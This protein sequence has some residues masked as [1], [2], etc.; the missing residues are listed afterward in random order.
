MFLVTATTPDNGAV[1]FG[2]DKISLVMSAAVDPTTLNEGLSL[3]TPDMDL[4]GVTRQIA[5]GRDDTVELIPNSPLEP[6]EY[7]VIVTSRL[8]SMFGEALS[9]GNSG[10]VYTRFTLS[11]TL[12]SNGGGSPS[13]DDYRL[14]AI[15]SLP[16]SQT[17]G[18]KQGEAAV[19]F[20]EPIEVLKVIAAVGG[21]LEDA[22][23]I[24]P[25]AVATVD[26]STLLL[27][28]S[29]APNSRYLFDMAV[30]GLESGQVVSFKL[31]Y[32]SYLDPGY[33][34]VNQVRS[35][36]GSLIKA[37]PNLAVF[38]M[39]SDCSVLAEGLSQAANGMGQR[40]RD[41]ALKQYTRYTVEYRLLR[42]FVMS[43]LLA[44]K[45]QKQLGQFSVSHDTAISPK[46]V[47]LLNKL[48][49]EV[50]HWEDVL[51]GFA[52]LGP[53]TPQSAVKGAKVFLV[54]PATRQIIRDEF[55]LPL[56]DPYIPS[57][58]HLPNMWEPRFKRPMP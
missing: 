13:D 52:G 30:R 45:D 48:Q 53:A 36:L 15:T 9:T 23:T 4:I 41:L 16:A 21:N 43:N 56:R 40:T 14:G 18:L 17:Y 26:D 39:A 3:I 11:Q 25:T 2:L 42:E 1:V 44:Q 55:K 28:W 57:R 54:N 19:V 10:V 50:L 8:T 32:Y 27:N 38:L 20:N 46:A 7:H 37:I 5:P 35:D 12:P 24:D 22:M 6:G 33:V 31:D 47:D 34:S 29:I 51:V 58:V 49:E